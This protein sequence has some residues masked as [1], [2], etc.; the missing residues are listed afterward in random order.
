MRARTD[1]RRGVLTLRF[2]DSLCGPA[3]ACGWRD[4]RRYP[5]AWARLR[6]WC[7]SPKP[8]QAAPSRTRAMKFDNTDRLGQPSAPTSMPSPRH[9]CRAGGR[10]CQA[11]AR[12]SARARSRRWPTPSVRSRSASQGAADRTPSSAASRRRSATAGR[13][14][15]SSSYCGR[16][17]AGSARSATSRRSAP[18]VCCCS[19]LGQ[20]RRQGFGRGGW[21]MLLN[22]STNVRQRSARVAP[23]GRLWALFCLGLRHLPHQSIDTLHGHLVLH[24]G[25]ASS[26]EVDDC[27]SHFPSFSRIG[28]AHKRLNVFGSMRNAASQSP[29][30]RAVRGTQH[31][32]SLPQHLAT[33]SPRCSRRSHWC[34]RQSPWHTAFPSPCS[35]PPAARLL[36]ACAVHRLR[37]RQGH[38]LWPSCFLRFQQSEDVRSGES[39][40]SSSTGTHRRRRK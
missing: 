13:R 6:L 20:L 1:A 16:S 14:S 27:C 2:G 34:T 4:G 29:P 17:E 32:A 11:S 3:A 37:R 31:R 28:A 36:R 15:A 12:E 23:H 38:G 40:A 10:T 7:R 35:R 30:P 39:W 19:A 21:Q 22:E 18:R 9:N 33:S 25:K 5:L 26:S 24:V 8:W